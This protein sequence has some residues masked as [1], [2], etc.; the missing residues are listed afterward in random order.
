[1]QALDELRPLIE[2]KMAMIRGD[3]RPGFD[4]PAKRLPSAADEHQL[5]INA[6]AL[7]R[8]LRDGRRLTI[9][10]IR[11][12]APYPEQAIAGLQDWLDGLEIGRRIA[13]EGEGADQVW[14][15]E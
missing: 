15:L 7:W 2:R 3:Q 4:L 1:M 11:E 10:Q 12:H 8:L 9:K 6:Y 14:W 5:E 13:G